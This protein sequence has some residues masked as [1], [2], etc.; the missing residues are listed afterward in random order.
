MASFS[1]YCSAF[2]MRP[3]GGIVMGYIGDKYGRKRALEISV[4]LMLFP[5]FLIGCLPT[6]KQIGYL[7]TVILVLLRL[8]QGLAVGGEMIGAY[9]FTIESC[10]GKGNRGFWGGVCKSTALCGTALGMGYVA[11]L[12]EVQS[13][14]DLYRWGWRLPFLSSIILGGL[15]AYLRF[16]IKES[17]SF[18]KVNAE[19]TVMSNKSVFNNIQQVF[20]IH[21]PEMIFVIFVAAFWA[22]GYYTCFVWMG[23]YTS[24]LIGGTP[25]Q[26]AW[27]INM[28][29][30]L[31]LIILLPLGG[32]IGDFARDIYQ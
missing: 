1:I 20:M 14:D 5:S 25:V 23:Y 15:A 2:F 31:L 32:A 10:E 24:N 7:A 9:V 18:E 26:H 27:V 8:M 30:I 22:T 4:A 3:L 19:M 16:R 29:M 28:G 12:R 17:E 6:F 11:I 21:W 13:S